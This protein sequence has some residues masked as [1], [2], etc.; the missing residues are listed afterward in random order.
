MTVFPSVQ[1]WASHSSASAST[2]SMPRPPV[3][4]VLAGRGVGRSV[5]ESCTPTCRQRVSQVSTRCAV[6]CACTWALVTSSETVSSTASTVSGAVVVQ[7]SDSRCPRVQSRAAF[8]PLDTGSDRAHPTAR[9]DDSR[10]MSLP[11]PV[12]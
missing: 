7:P 6:L 2:R 10:T 9:T 1:G 3:R 4:S 5:E 11:V 8:T 12:C